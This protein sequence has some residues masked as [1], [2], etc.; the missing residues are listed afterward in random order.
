MKDLFSQHAELYRAYRPSYPPEL[1]DHILSFV[2]DK[3]TAWDCG[4]GNGQAAL[5]LAPH[6]AKVHATDISASQLA[7]AA[8]HPHIEYLQCP[9]EV[10]PF[11]AAYFS[12]IT[13]AQA[14]HWFNWPAFHEEIRRVAKDNAVVAIWHYDRF[15]T[16]VPALNRLMDH[17]YFDVTGPYWDERRKYVDEHYAS[18]PFPYDPLPVK[19]FRYQASWTKEQLTGYL[20]SWSAV[21]QYIRQEGHSPLTLIGQQLDALLA[22][23]EPISVSFPIFLKLGILKK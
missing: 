4:T 10:T 1:V 17:F 3:H 19:Q 14:F 22:D 2:S 8:P 13:V 5:L 15:E 7:V 11:P 16:E 9:A 6:F 12:L 20:S 18:L 21:Q 23:G